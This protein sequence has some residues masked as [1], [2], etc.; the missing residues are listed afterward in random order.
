M[1]RF[2]AVA[3]AVLTFAALTIHTPNAFADAKG[4]IAAKSKEAMSNYDNFEAETAR[5]LLT[6]AVAIAKKNKLDNDP[7]LAKVHLYLGVVYFAGLNQADNAK[8]EFVAAATIDPKIQIEAA[9]R[10]PDLAKLLDDARVEAAK[11]PVP[12]K[13]DPV[14]NGGGTP[15]AEPEPD[16]ATV[17][18][19]QH[20]AIES[21]P[22]GSTTPIVA[23]A[24]EDVVAAKI[25]IKFRPEGATEF[26]EAPMV[27]DGCKYSGSIPK[28]QMKGKMM[29]YY[30]VALDSKGSAVA[31][32]GSA[33]APNLM[34][35]TAAIAG[36]DIEDP[37]K[38]I[39]KPPA[40]VMGGK[41]TVFLAI[42]GGTG[43][44]A[45]S[46]N[47]EITDSVVGCGSPVCF[48]PGLLT[49]APELGYYVS[50]KTSIS[51]VARLGLP[52][53]ANTLGH[54]TL[55]P[56]ALLRL[57]HSLGADG[58]G[59]AII[60][61]LG[62]GIVR[63]VVAINGGASGMDKDTVAMG[64]L[65]LGAGLGYVASLGSSLAFFADGTATAGVPVTKKLGDARLNLGV[66]LDLVLGLRLSF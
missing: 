5:K 38:R 36:S 20:K 22:I 26:T 56:A 18:G 17:M 13:Q 8:A 59:L 42:A 15:V 32:S 45:V 41:K 11:A 4:D 12:V 60:G 21:A 55:G 51:L 3:C 52:L 44:G 6:E 46:G 35:L 49:F 16:C 40:I 58:K 62:A 53:G 57:R 50:T 37:N 66:Q 65:L 64:P 1:S 54:A 29:H 19:L 9:Y 7:V 30:V 61:S 23:Y 14:N 48:A 43:G 24:G 25:A 47:T 34:D 28:D 10:R 2:V 33:G 39:K 63:N 27:K 31:S